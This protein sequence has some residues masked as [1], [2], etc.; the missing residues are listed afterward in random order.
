MGGR[1]CD[2]IPA[3]KRGAVIVF[4]DCGLFPHMTVTQNIEFGLVAK[5]ISRAERAAK[6][7]RMLDLMQLGDKAAC[8]PGE[9][10][11]GQKQRVALA[12]ACV[13][14]P[15]ALLLDEPF[16][17]LDTSLKEVTYELVVM[18]QRTLKITTILVTH[19]K[20]EAFMLSQRVAVISNGR[21]QQFDT[22]QRIYNNPLTRQVADFIG[23]AN[24]IDGNVS[25]GVFI[26][27]LGQFDAAGCHDGSAQLMLR[28]D[29]I[30]LECTNGFPCTILEKIYKGGTTTYRITVMGYCLTVNSYDN[31][32]EPGQETFV[33]PAADAGCIWNKIPAPY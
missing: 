19:D 2:H 18:L 21:I 22:P 14:E 15:N 27:P 17:S 6:S 13:L 20:K 7:A 24:Y 12:R 29:Q 4:Q 31:G 9:L 33:R 5:K 3:R 26:C 16:S 30:V 25:D 11:G 1:C 32:F 10:S 8:Y 28:Y 23:E